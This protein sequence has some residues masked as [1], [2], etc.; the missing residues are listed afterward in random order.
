MGNK[1]AVHHEAPR[2]T[3]DFFVGMKKQTKLRRQLE[4]RPTRTAKLDRLGGMYHTPCTK[5]RQRH[6]V[7]EACCQNVCVC[8]KRRPAGEDRKLKKATMPN[9][10][11]A[12]VTI[13]NLPAV[14]GDSRLA[15]DAQ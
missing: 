12:Y 3:T 14:G 9:M 8:P 15:V 10:P 2:D 7:A 4:N 1:I 13:H 11:R 5:E 6:G